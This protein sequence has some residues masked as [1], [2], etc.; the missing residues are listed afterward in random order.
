MSNLATGTHP[1]YDTIN[2]SA[3]HP[4]LQRQEVL[5]D[6]VVRRYVIRCQARAVS[7]LDRRSLPHQHFDH[8]RV[9]S[10]R[11]VVQ[12]GVARLVRRDGV[13][14]CRKRPNKDTS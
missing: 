8:L 13:R 11:G 7:F 2:L 4:E 12:G 5:P 1:P 14:S 9:P 6:D 3:A 10:L